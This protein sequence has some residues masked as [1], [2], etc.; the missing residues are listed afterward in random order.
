MHHP[1]TEKM[2]HDVI[3]VW[4]S[5]A[6]LLIT[7]VE[8]QSHQRCP[9]SCKCD[10]EGSG[11]RV[12]CQPSD[13][14]VNINLSDIDSD[15]QFLEILP[16]KQSD[17]SVFGPSLPPVF[18]DFP[19][20]QRLIIRDNGIQYIPPNTARQLSRLVTLDLSGMFCDNVIEREVNCTLPWYSIISFCLAN[21]ISSLRDLSLDNLPGLDS[22]QLSANLIQA[23]GSNDLRPLRYLRALGLTTNRIDNIAP[24]AFRNQQ[25]IEFLRLGTNRLQNLPS[26]VFDDLSRLRQLDLSSNQFSAIPDGKKFGDVIV[27]IIRNFCDCLFSLP[28][29]EAGK[30]I[31]CLYL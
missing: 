26:A 5:F 19:Q 15:V 3:L 21:Q 20:L 14:G 12:R 6:I 18:Q 4:A 24:D 31:N 23:I 8:G 10:F 29:N 17:H 16:F 9:L 2:A 25:N 22:L 27:R 28:F 1:E 7:F 30:L 13:S 11:K